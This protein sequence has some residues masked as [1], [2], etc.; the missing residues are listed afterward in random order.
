M[1]KV[2]RSTTKA[3]KQTARGSR[4]PTGLKTQS[5]ETESAPST[6]EPPVLAARRFR[7]KHVFWGQTDYVEARDGKVWAVMVDGSRLD[8]SKTYSLET[9]LTYVK[10]GK[11]E[12]LT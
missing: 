2:K 6:K 4:K 8:V 11:W 3:T 5:S 12:E 7:K 9:C 10:A 1:K